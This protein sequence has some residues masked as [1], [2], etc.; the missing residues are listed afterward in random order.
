M[1]KNNSANG[2]RQI[3][4]FRASFLLDSSN[5]YSRWHSLPERASRG[6]F[7]VMHS[8]YRLNIQLNGVNVILYGAVITNSEGVQQLA[9][10]AERETFS[11]IITS[12]DACFQ[13]VWNALIIFFRRNSHLKMC[14]CW[15]QQ[16]GL[17]KNFKKKISWTKKEIREIFRTL[18]HSLK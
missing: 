2:S 10:Y 11:L 17:R 5:S 12:N 1:Y 13:L 18:A 9:L 6:N 15:L 4:L 14:N 16:C 3:I 7:I 8:F